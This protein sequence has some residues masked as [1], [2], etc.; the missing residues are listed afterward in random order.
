V[1]TYL[2]KQEQL[3]KQTAAL[4][5][6]QQAQSHAK[7]LKAQEEQL[8]QLKE[9]EA[10]AAELKLRQEQQQQKRAQVIIYFQFLVSV[11]CWS[12][13]VGILRF[14]YSGPVKFRNNGILYEFFA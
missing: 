8:L 3:L 6:Q 13:R 4:L 11:V 7:A 14:L 9:E 2:A 1:A 5:D 10:L 12:Y